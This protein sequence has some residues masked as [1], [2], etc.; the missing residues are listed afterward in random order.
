MKQTILTILLLSAIVVP[1]QA[2]LLDVSNPASPLNP[3]NPISPLNLASDEH[4]ARPA[5]KHTPYT[6][7]KFKGYEL[8]TKGYCRQTESKELKDKI[9]S[10]LIQEGGKAC[11]NLI[12]K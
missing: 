10:C 8:C 4:K 7:R 3:I 5:T 9:E 11:L 6:I 1:A 2:D 12:I